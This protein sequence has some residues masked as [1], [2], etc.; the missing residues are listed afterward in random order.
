M[1]VEIAIALG[2]LAVADGIVVL[3]VYR[4]CSDFYCFLICSYVQ[5][6][7]FFHCT[8]LLFF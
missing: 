2:M 3:L 4:M 7:I 6:C 5:S 1:V 8:C